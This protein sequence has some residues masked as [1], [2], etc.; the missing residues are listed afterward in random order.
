MKRVINI[1]GKLFFHPSYY[2]KD[3]IECYEYG[4]VREQLLK[5]L[6]EIERHGINQEMACQL[7]DITEVSAAYWQNLQAKWAE[8]SE[9]WNRIKDRAID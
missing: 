1:N 3:L 2:I 6:P 8:G 5:V 9:A 7:S 4:S